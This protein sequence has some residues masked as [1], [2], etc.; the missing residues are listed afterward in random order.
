[1]R[2]FF[3]DDPNWKLL[4]TIE[5]AAGPTFTDETDWA[6]GGTIPAIGECITVPSANDNQSTDLGLVVFCGVITTANAAAIVARGTCTFTLT[7]IEV[8]AREHVVSMANVPNVMP[9]LAMDSTPLTG[10]APQRKVRIDGRGIQR[11]AFR[12]SGFANVPGT[13]AEFHLLVR[14]E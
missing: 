6:A 8:A 1:M 3:P 14:L 11:M 10:V 9:D 12:L 13:A 2:N 5:A 7:P 4:R